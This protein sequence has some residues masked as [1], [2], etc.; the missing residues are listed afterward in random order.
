MCQCCSSSGAGRA[1]FLGAL[2]KRKE[3]CVGNGLNRPCSATDSLETACIK[4]AKRTTI[5]AISMQTRASTIS[6]SLF[7]TPVGL[8]Q[9]V[10]RVSGPNRKSS[11]DIGCGFPQKTLKN[12]PE[13]PFLSHCFYSSAFFPDSFREAE[14][15]VYFPTNF[16]IAGNLFCTR[17]TGSQFYLCLIQGSP[18]SFG[19]DCS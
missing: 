15:Y 7:A 6:N 4:H 12:G 2:S 18:S 1:V 8:V 11:E 13:T 14:T 3:E 5:I 17:S 19:S 9:H 16:P 10:F